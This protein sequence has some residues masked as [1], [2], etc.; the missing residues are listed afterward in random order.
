MYEAARWEIAVQDSQDGLGQTTRELYIPEAPR[1][2]SAW[3]TG[4]TRG[5]EQGREN[6]SRCI[7]V[8]VS[9]RLNATECL[10]LTFYLLIYLSSSAGLLLLV[11]TCLAKVSQSFSETRPDCRT[12]SPGML[13]AKHEI[14]CLWVLIEYIRGNS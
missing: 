2:Q 14:S 7:N 1:R 3:L 11:V 6:V 8:I 13:Q 9:E 5:R 10:L 12:S 4:M